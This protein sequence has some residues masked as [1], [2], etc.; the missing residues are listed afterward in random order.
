MPSAPE[1]SGPRSKLDAIFGFDLRALALFRIAI[2]AVL[3]YDLADRS[4]ALAAHYT[5][6]GVLPADALAGQSRMLRASIHYYLSGSLAGESALFAVHA[7]AAL[8]LLLGWRTKAANVV[9]WYLLASLHVRNPGVSGLGGDGFLRLMLFW[10]LFLPLGA[11]WSLDRRRAG[12]EAPPVRICSVATA[13]LMLQICL[14]YVATGYLK[15]GPMW[16]DGSAVFYAL[17]LDQFEM[18]WTRWMREQTALL[19]LLTYGTKWFELLGPLLL[20]VPVYVPV[21]RMAAIAAFVGFHVSLAAFLHISPFPI[22][23]IAA[24]MVF[25]PTEAWEALAR[26]RGARAP[27][28]RESPRLS[29]P[30]WVQALC[31]VLIAYAALIVAGECGLAPGGRDLLG[32]AVGAPA[33]ALRIQQRWGMFAPQPNV[34]DVWLIVD[35]RLAGGAEIDPFHDAPVER[36]KPANI[37][38]HDGPFRWRMYTWSSLL[39]PSVP[40][41]IENHRLFAEY[42]CRDWNARHDGPERLAS[43]KT[44]GFEERTHA[45][46]VDPPRGFV[47]WEHECGVGG[48]KGPG[49]A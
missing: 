13:A 33:R 40:H 16:W 26:W 39:R 5:D 32:S 18:P 28:R 43:L 46:R 30:R 27:E 48:R 36:V 9:C 45:D 34:R 20:F 4:Q 35:G 2:A 31:G 41:F 8:A 12:G 1:N 3:L 29:S 14:M 38:D 17:H 21:V 7:L 10:S 6:W 44:L 22:M 23:C 47:I 15:N 42:L 49:A 24:W 11:R 37:P 25:V 19:P